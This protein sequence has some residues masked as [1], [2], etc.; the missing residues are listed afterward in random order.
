MLLSR[1]EQVRNTPEDYKTSLSTVTNVLKSFGFKAAEKA[2]TSLGFLAVWDVFVKLLVAKRQLLIAVAGIFS[3]SI[4]L[5]RFSDFY[6]KDQVDQKLWIFIRQTLVNREAELPVHSQL[7]VVG[8]VDTLVKQK[9]HRLCEA[10]E[11][12]VGAI[13]GYAEVNNIIM[14]Q[15]ASLNAVKDVASLFQLLSTITALLCIRE[16]DMKTAFLGLPLADS[17]AQRLKGL[18]LDEFLFVYMF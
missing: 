11:L 14:Q 18:S 4:E 8:A 6:A 16:F 1:L 2:L 10:A 5:K 17:N 9:Y 7:V 15:L 3:D 12:Q 13:D